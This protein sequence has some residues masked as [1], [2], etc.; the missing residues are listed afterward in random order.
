MKLGRGEE[1]LRDIEHQIERINL[2]G[3]NVFRS[4]L[5]A[6]KAELL[7]NGAATAISL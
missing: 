1:A 5:V 3:E 6:Q 4:L 2:S 7:S